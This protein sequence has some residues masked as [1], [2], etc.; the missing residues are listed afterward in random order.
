MSESAEDTF[1]DVNWDKEPSGEATMTWFHGPCRSLGEVRRISYASRKE[2]K[3]GSVYQHA[4]DVHEGR[5]PYLLHDD[6]EGDQ[7]VREDNPV[8]ESAELGLVVDLELADGTRVL[9]PGASTV[10]EPGTRRLLIAGEGVQVPV[11]VEQ[12]GHHVPRE[13]ITG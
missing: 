5:L 3:G 2:G 13:G 4:F 9:L 10:V 12:R 8:P 6:P 1:K 11:Q 7:V